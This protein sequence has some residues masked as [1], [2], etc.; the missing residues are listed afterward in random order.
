VKRTLESLGEAPIDRDYDVMFLSCQSATDL[1]HLGPI[2]KWRERCRR[3]IVYVDELWAHTVPVRPGE[4]ANL[5]EFDHIFIG[6]EHSVAAVAAATG[7]PVSFLPIGIDTLRFSP[8]PDAPARVIDVFNMGRRSAVTH[9]AIKALARERNW[10]YVYDT[11]TGRCAVHDPRD[12]R[13]HLASTIK[14]AR[15]FI[16][17]VAKITAPAETGGQQ[18]VGFRFY[19]GAAGGAVLIGEPPRC[20]SFDEHFGWEDS[21]IYMPYGT[22]NPAAVMDALDAQPD[23]VEAIRR[24]NVVSSLRRHDWVYRWARVLE[25]AGLQPTA[26]VGERRERLT[27]LAAEVE[28]AP[29]RNGKDEAPLLRRAA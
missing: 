26:R 3:L 9:D 25:V 22:S 19:E 23:R 6:Q 20:P 27:R 4:M 21:V 29:E 28:G 7:Q 17:N 13:E 11:T 15:F 2:A 8:F 10:H 12:H 24:R 18:E 16:T 5:A 1:K 14:R